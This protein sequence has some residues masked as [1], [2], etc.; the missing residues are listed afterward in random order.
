MDAQLQEMLD[1]Y[2][3]RKTLSEY[4]HGCDRCDEETMRGVYF[5]N[6]SWDDHGAIQ[7]NGPDFTRL[8]TGMV[9]SS[10]NTLSHLLGQSRI[11]VDGDTAAAETYFLAVA[12]SA[13]ENGVEM[14]N[15]LGGRFVDKLQKSDGR[16]L[17]KHRTVVRDWAISMPIESDWTAESGLRPG[18]RSNADPVY[19]AM[20]SRHGGCSP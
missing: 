11:R 12:T 14:C 5:G 9:A 20:A 8:M 18:E 13:G 2:Q 4:C 16:W 17:I 3:I 6:D 15:Q 1:H 19:E 7:A 10:T